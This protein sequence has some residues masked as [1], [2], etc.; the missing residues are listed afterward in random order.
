MK[1]IISLVLLQVFLMGCARTILVQRASVDTKN[2]TA[3]YIPLNDETLKVRYNYLSN[4]LN[5]DTYGGGRNKSSIKLDVPKEIAAYFEK[6]GNSITIGPQSPLPA[7][8][9][10]IVGYDEL[11]GWDMGDILKSLEIKIFSNPNSGDTLRVS[12]KEMTIFNSR[13]KPKTLVP[14]MLDSL[15]VHL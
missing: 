2:P 6:K 14:Q 9:T 15:F 8:D 3:Y 13:P 11:W 7:G 10:L 1:F 5:Y 4:P 12:F